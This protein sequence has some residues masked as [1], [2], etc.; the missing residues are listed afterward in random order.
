[1]SIFKDQADFMLLAGQ[2]TDGKTSRFKQAGL[3]VSLIEE[4][5]KEFDLATYQASMVN[6]VKEAVD[7][8][9][10]TAGYLITVLG[11]VG[12]Q[13][14]W[15]AVH[16][17]NMAKVQ[18]N[19]EKRDDGKVLKNNEYKAIAKEKMMKELKVLL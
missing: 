9:V 1:M 14:A 10:V 6:E 11:E 15:N 4:E 16:E 18:G 5:T 12:A 2:L 8:L 17:S 7:I 3:Y 19:V 13:K